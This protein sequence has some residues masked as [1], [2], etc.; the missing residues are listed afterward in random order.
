MKKKSTLLNIKKEYKSYDFDKL[1]NLKPLNDLLDKI[2]ESEKSYLIKY[3]TNG[4]LSYN[5]SKKYYGI[6]APISFKSYNNYN[7]DYRSKFSFK[8]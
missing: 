2:I 4:K 8:F 6:D 1:I 7:E 5:F 3:V